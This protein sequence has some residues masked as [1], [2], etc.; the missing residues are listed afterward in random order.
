[1]VI[2]PKN[3]GKSSL[4]AHLMSESS[5]NYVLLDCDV[6]KNSCMEGC[7]SLT[8]EGITK[9]IWIGELTPLNNLE[10]YL[11][12]IR[13]LYAYSREVWFGKKLLINTMGYVTGLGEYLLY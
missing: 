2:G 3:S 9:K 7:V 5:H 11:R 1:M 13:Y 8:H 12:A 10:T 4:C 6:G